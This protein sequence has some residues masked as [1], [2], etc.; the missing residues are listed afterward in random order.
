MR[1][2]ALMAMIK[3]MIAQ[4]GQFII[5]THSPILLAYPHAT[6]YHFDNGNVQTASFEE[7]E[8][9]RLTRDFLNNPSLYLSHL[10]DEDV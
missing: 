3:E 4:G 6:I 1:Q 10:L 8:R 5:A 7:L 9:V 2:L